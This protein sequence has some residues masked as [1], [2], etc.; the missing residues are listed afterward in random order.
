MNPKLLLVLCKVVYCKRINS[1]EKDQLAG[2]YMYN[3][4]AKTR[5]YLFVV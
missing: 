4:A 2:S 3:S 1:L 5:K